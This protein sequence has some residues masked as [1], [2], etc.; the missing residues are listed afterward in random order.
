M[1]ILVSRGE[2]PPYLVYSVTEFM[3][4]L[5]PTPEDGQKPRVR[6]KMRSS[7][8]GLAAQ[9]RLD[10]DGLALSNRSY[11]CLQREKCKYA[12][13]LAMMSD[14]ELLRIDGVGKVSL[15]D[16]RTALHEAGFTGGRLKYD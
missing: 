10:I 13:Q 6:V 8:S 11:N 1:A 12:Y 15:L 2:V 16:I 7:A 4:G 3:S 9:L 14:A 5:V